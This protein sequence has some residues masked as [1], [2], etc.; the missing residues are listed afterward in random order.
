MFVLLQTRA[1]SPSHPALAHASLSRLVLCQERVVRD[2][3]VH[4]I[5]EGTNEVMRVVIERNMGKVWYE[6]G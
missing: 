6:G 3:R 5:L 1:W 4:S 2:L